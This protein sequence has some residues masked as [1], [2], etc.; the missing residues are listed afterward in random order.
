MN[1]STPTIRTERLAI[2]EFI[3]SH[4]ALLEQAQAQGVLARTRLDLRDTAE[5]RFGQATPDEAVRLKVM[6]EEELD[7][8]LSDMRLA[9]VTVQQQVEREVPSNS[10]T[11]RG[12]IL[13][14]L[15][16]AFAFM[17]GF[18]IIGSS[19]NMGDGGI[20]FFSIGLPI[21]SGIG[22]FLTARSK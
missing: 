17:I 7:A 8:F 21:A 10:H 4:R 6:F 15:A 3:Q 14:I 11:A 12:M 5:A 19:R 20:L 2:R 1:E 16:A 22:V 18:V 13:G 9:T